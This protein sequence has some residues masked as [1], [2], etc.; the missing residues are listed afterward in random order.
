MKIL[1]VGAHLDDVELGCEATLARS[2][3]LPGTEGSIYRVK[4][5]REIGGFDTRIDGAAED[6]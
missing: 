3:Y 6:T 2:L 5:T 1:A 4:A